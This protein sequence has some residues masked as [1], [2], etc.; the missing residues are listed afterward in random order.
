MKVIASG[1]ALAAAQRAY[2]LLEKGVDALTAVADGLAVVEDD[3]DEMTVGFGGLPNA[4]G[5]LQLDAACR[6]A[7]LC[8]QP[9][10]TQA[11]R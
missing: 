7:V 8:G 1:N 2:A 6:A 9:E 10:A 5:V 11:R 4:E 3:P